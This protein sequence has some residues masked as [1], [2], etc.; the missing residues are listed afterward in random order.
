ML[1]AGAAVRKLADGFFNISGGAAA[2]NGDFYFVDAQWQ[3]IHRWSVADS[4]LSTVHDAP[5]EPVNLAFD[6]AGNLLVVSYAGQRHGLHVQAR[7]AAR[8]VR[9][10][11]ARRRRA[12]PRPHHRPAGGRLAVSARSDIGPSAGEAHALRVA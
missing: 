10:P 6:K 1:E 2:P 9:R 8:P 11:E 5:L 3:R 4:R 7:R 12:A